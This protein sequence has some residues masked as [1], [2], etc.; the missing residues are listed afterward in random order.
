MK[1]HSTVRVCGASSTSPAI[2]LLGEQVLPAL[3]ELSEETS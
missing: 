3:G 2:R 1:L